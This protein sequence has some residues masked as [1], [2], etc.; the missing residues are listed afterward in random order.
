MDQNFVGR[1]ARLA[2]APAEVFWRECFLRSALTRQKSIKD[3]R[4]LGA[5]ADACGRMYGIRSEG[6]RASQLC[7]ENG[8]EVRELTI[9]E[10]PNMEIFAL[11]EPPSEILVRAGLL[12]GCD[13]LVKESGMDAFL[14][15]FCC[16][17]VVL[18]HEFF[19]FLETRDSKTVFTRT[20][21]EPLG[22]LGRKVCLPPLAEIAAMGFA[23]EM[24]GLEWS[25]FLLDCVMLYANNMPSALAMLERLERSA[26]ECAR[27]T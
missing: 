10:L 26:A 12:S 24:L 21:R 15:D 22:F 27:S 20:Y 16:V 11:F 3:M 17:D 9:P 13:R 7:A 14:G 2:S 23:Q 25:P 6:A 5:A 8:L 4:T 19:H 1:I 18:C